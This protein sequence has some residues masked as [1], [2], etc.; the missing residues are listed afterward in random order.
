MRNDEVIEAPVDRNGLTKRYTE[1]ALDWIEENRDEP[2]FLYIPQA[3]PGSTSEPFSSEEFRGKSRNGPWGDS[4][5]ELDWSTGRI[6]D[7]LV[8]LGIEEDTLV[9]WTSDNGAPIRPEPGNL[10]RGSNLPLHGRGYTTSEGAFRV[11]TIIWQPG[12]IPAGT[13]CEELTTTMDLLPTFVS[14]A[15]GKIEDGVKRDGYDVTGL[16]LGEEGAETPYEY[17]AYYYLNQLQAIRSGPWKLFVPLENFPQ[18]PHYTKKNQ[19]NGPLLFHLYDDVACDT[20]V[21]DQHPD[22]VAKLMGYAE[23]M[24]KDLG[25]HENPGPG[26]RPPGKVKNPVPVVKLK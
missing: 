13:V 24:R 26:I 21:A 22:T 2:F 23:E 16:Y 17:F 12:T 7:H 19:T 14:M 20:N 1:V 15:G 5:E 8:K 11:P 4:I 18:H 10:T 6:L 9:I 25:D 3:M